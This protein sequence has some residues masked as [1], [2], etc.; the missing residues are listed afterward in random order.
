M[1]NALVSFGLPDAFKDLIVIAF[2]EGKKPLAL[3]LAQ[4]AFIYDSRV[5]DAEVYHFAGFQ[6]TRSSFDLSRKLWDLVKSRTSSMRFYRG[7]MVAND[8]NFYNMIICY[9]DSMTEENPKEYCTRVVEFDNESDSN[10]RISVDELINGKPKP[11]RVITYPCARASLALSPSKYI[12]KKKLDEIFIL[13]AE[14]RRTNLCPR[15]S[16]DITDECLDA[17]I[18]LK[19]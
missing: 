17:G 3:R 10:L 14:K 11:Y 15:F 13:E 7:V 4:M 19:T 12:S 5:V 1:S 2:T 16:S 8:I 6:V 9:L 18:I